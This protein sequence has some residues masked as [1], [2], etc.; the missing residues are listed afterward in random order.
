[1]YHAHRPRGASTPRALL[2]LATGLVESIGWHRLP[3]PLGVATL[4]AIRKRLRQENLFDTSTAPTIDRPALH[5]AAPRY[6]VARTPDGSYNDLAQP[7]MGATGARFGRNAPIARTFREPPERLMT[8]NPRTVSREL[9]TRHTFQPATTLNLL[10][11]A[12]LQFQVH[13]WLSHGRNEPNEPWQVPLTSDDDWPE[14]PMRILRTRA[15]PTRAAGHDGLPPTYQNTATAWWDGSQI[16]GSGADI[17]ARL[18]SGE[19][20]TLTVQ[21]D[22]L[23]PLDDNG[24]DRTGVSGN[25]WIGLSLMHTLFTLE[26]NA[27]AQRFADE[28]PS[29]SDDDVFDHARL[30]N[31]ALMAKIHTL[32]WTPAIIAHPSARYALRANWWGIESERLSRVF[33]R[34]SSNEVVSGIPGSPT[35]HHGTPYSMTEEFVAVYRMHP[36]LPDE[37]TFR[38]LDDNRVLLQTEFPGVAF[39]YARHVLEQVGFANAL[40]SFGMQ[41]PGAITLH[42]F[43]RTLQGLVDLQGNLNDLAAIDVLRSRERG[44]P[45]YNNFRAMV[46]KPRLQ[47]FEQLTPKRHWVEQIRHVYNGDID[48]VDLMIGLYAEPLPEGF[49][50]S[51]T[52]FR[53]FILMASRRLKSDRFFTT[54]YT[55]RIYTQLGLDWIANNDFASVLLRHAPGLGAALRG[56]DNPFAPWRTAIR[57]TYGDYPGRSDHHVTGRT[58]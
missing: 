45:R 32:E 19:R 5:G 33:G 55:P 31:A 38:A 10:A 22:G 44:V 43:P 37:L 24:I 21:P 28:F 49:G 27:I 14:R 11:A 42:N 34:L 7:A 51:D 1:M 47:A 15:D 2:R 20:G 36:M 54:D 29:W 23:L 48:S 13:D 9:L 25:W 56:I 12:W 17:L 53:I 18:R 30:V 39:Q 4:I 16:Y 35:D 57:G 58:G 41:H 52:A 50:F 40:F 3:L 8:P 6:L 46:H 26:H